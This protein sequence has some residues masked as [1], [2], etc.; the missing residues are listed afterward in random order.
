M[1][2]AIYFLIASWTHEER[3]F[4]GDWVGFG[5]TWM[6]PWTWLTFIFEVSRSPTPKDIPEPYDG[7]VFHEQFHSVY[8]WNSKG[9]WSLL[10]D[11]GMS[12]WPT[13]ND[14]WYRVIDVFF[15]TISFSRIVLIAGIIILFSGDIIRARE[16]FH[17]ATRCNIIAI[18]FG[19][20]IAL[21]T[22]ALMFYYF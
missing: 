4:L 7:R 6:L 2:R 20:A 22:I 8:E 16:H 19:I 9:I 14:F 5:L 17:C 18:I 15:G 21:I 3:S 12:L 1:M 10:T 13:A 11:P